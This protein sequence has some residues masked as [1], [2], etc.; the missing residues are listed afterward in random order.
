MITPTGGWQTYKNVSLPLTNPPTG[1]HELFLITRNPGQ[2]ASLLNINWIEFIGKGAAQTAAPDVTAS[3]TPLTG[4]APLPVKFTSTATDPDGAGDRLAYAWDFGVPGTDDGHVDGA[5]AELHVRQRGQLQRHADRHRQAGRHDDQELHDQGHRA[6]GLRAPTY[7]DD[8]DGTDLGAGWD[9]VRRDQ[10]LERLRRRAEHHRPRTATSTAT[11]NNAKNIV[12]RTGPG[13]RRGRRRSR[14]TQAGNRQYHQAGL[15]VYGDDDNYTKFDRLATTPPADPATEHF[16]F[17]NEVAG[18]PRNAAADSGPQLAATY[19]ADFYMKIESDGTQISGYYVARRH[20]LDAGRA[21][22]R[23]C[24]RTPRVGF[25]ALGQRGGDARDRQVRLVHARR[26][27]GGGAAR[28]PGDDFDGTSL[29]KTRWNSIVREDTS[30]YN[31]AD[32]DLTHDDGAGRHRREATRTSSS[33]RADHTGEDYVLETK[34]SA[35]DAEQ[36]FQQA[37]ILIYGR[38]TTTTSSSTRSPTATTR[39][40]NR[41]RT[42]PRWPARSSSR[43]RRSTSPP[44]VTGDLAA[45]DQVGHQ[46]PGRDLV[47]RDDLDE[48]RRPVTNADGRSAFGLYTAGVNGSR[49]D[50]DL[51]LLQGQRRRRAARAAA[52]HRRRSSPR[53]TATPTAG[54]APLAAAFAAAATDADGDAL[55]TAWDFDGNGTPT[56]PAPRRSTTFTTAGTQTVS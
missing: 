3:A 24:R 48:R 41:S 31:V 22:R 56:P 23:T 45:A 50:R 34:L 40:I 36:L 5:D 37:G 52:Q 51:R 54:F 21:S 28:G 38:T 13:R 1:T 9:V 15:I 43:S 47:R 19:P 14:S 33:R 46:L 35:L 29:D 25:F 4:A 16:E 44:G 18:T 10:A 11:T 8:F 53:P 42:A 26:R 17:I 32:G 49:A 30:L 2:T 7:R 6:R 55:R 39:A 12:L 27:P 20:D